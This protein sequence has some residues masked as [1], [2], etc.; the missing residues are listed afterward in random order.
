MK[1]YHTFRAPL[2]RKDGFPPAC[3]TIPRELSGFWTLIILLPLL[4]ACDSPE[5][6]SR[7]G[8]KPVYVEVA[9][10]V[11][12]PIQTRRIIT[13]TLEA[14]SMVKIF[15][16][17]PGRLIDLPFYEGDPVHQ[18]DVLA[19]IDDSLLLSE[20]DKASAALKQARQDL[21]RL[22]SLVK[23]QLA[24][25]EELSRAMTAV[26]QTASEVE[27]LQNRINRSQIRAPFDGIITQRLREPGDVV[28]VYSHILS[29]I[30]PTY[31]K[32]DI[33]VSALLL[34]DIAPQQTVN[35][36]IDALGEKLFSAEVSRIHPTVDPSTRQ[37]IVE[38]KLQP[39]PDGARPGQ[40]C[41]VVIESRTSPRLSI[42]FPALRHD[43]SG[44]FVYKV[45]ADNQQV[46]KVRVKS[47]IQLADRVEIIEGLELGEQI[48]TRGFIGLRDG[49]KVSVV[50]HGGKSAS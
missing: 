14:A 50:T 10:V 11:R 49:A 45:T 34:S 27:V 19:R 40:L 24:S 41:R 6:E 37:G 8:P 43:N 22:Q 30:D 9:E 1:Y 46:R 47:G 32:A 33:P 4:A 26:E 35:M 20:R 2:C 36:R 7:S 44:E 3:M 18:G 28:P 42:P 21:Q 5:K 17:E 31:L 23:R 29:L 12:A 38:I 39:V 16:E 25:Q 15:N 13:G 48:V